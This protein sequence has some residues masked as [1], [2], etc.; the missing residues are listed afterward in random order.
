[1]RAQVVCLF[2]LAFNLVNC[3]NICND[4][5]SAQQ[6]EVVIVGAGV[7]GLVAAQRFSTSHV[8]FTVLEARDRLGGRIHT[9]TEGNSF[10]DVNPFT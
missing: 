10:L 1:M 2:L 9:V 8:D 6:N 7:A 3:Q 5:E 4:L